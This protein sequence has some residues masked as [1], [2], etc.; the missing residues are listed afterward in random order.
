MFLCDMCGE[1]ICEGD[2]Y[3]DFCDANYCCDCVDAA[4]SE[5]AWD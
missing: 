2:D 4:R 5:A 1:P 3:Y